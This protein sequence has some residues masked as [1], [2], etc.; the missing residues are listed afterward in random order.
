VPIIAMT[1]SAVDGERE[2]CLATGMDDYVTKPV[3]MAELEK[4]LD[5]WITHAGAPSTR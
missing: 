2:R 3:V 4:T 1:A 5:R